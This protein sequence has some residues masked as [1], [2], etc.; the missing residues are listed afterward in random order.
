LEAPYRLLPVLETA[1][2]IMPNRKAYIGCNLTMHYETNHY[3]SF[4]ELYNKFKN[5]QFKGEFVI[6]FKGNYFQSKSSE[7]SKERF[8]FKK[9]GLKLRK[10]DS[11][12]RDRR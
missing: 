7:S 11:G 8:G 1:S 12:N 6:V 5:L 4:S 2:E 3:G 10:Y 9:S